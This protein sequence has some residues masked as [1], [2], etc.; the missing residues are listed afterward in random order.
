MNRRHLLNTLPVGLM[1]VTGCIGTEPIAEQPTPTRSETP[2]GLCEKAF[3]DLDNSNDNCNDTRF[4]Y[5][6]TEPISNATTEPGETPYEGTFD[7]YLEVTITT[8]SSDSL[9]LRGCI[10]GSYENRD[11]AMPVA[12]KLPAD[13]NEYNLEFGPFAHPGGISKYHLWIKGCKAE[14]SGST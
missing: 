8:N 9:I 14:A 11:K 6:D 13:Q 1:F 12:R 2:A 10:K 3:T 7:D 4:E 5:V